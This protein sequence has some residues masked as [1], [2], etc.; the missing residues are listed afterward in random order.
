MKPLFTIKDMKNALILLFASA[1]PLV[2][3]CATSHHHAVTWDY[4][5]IEAYDRGGLEQEL[6]RLGKEEWSVASSAAYKWQE[7]ETP[8]LTVILKRS[9][10]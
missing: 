3:G 8:K 1:V 5:V 4:K 7:N 6:V 2:S 10:N 9:Q